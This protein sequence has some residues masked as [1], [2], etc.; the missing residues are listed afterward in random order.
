MGEG[1]YNIFGIVRVFI[2]LLLIGFLLTLKSERTY[3]HK[4]FALYLGLLIID[5]NG[6]WLTSF[7]VEKFPNFDMFRN[8]LAFLQLPVFYLYI[9]SICY[10]NFKLKAIHIL[11]IIPLLA[12]NTVLIPNYYSVSLALKSEFMENILERPEIVFIYILIHVLAFVYTILIFLTLRRFRKVYLE[13]YA[14][15]N[16]YGYKWL[17]RL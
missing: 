2:C 8:T 14:A 10:S 9:L 13:N 16:S 15:S 11:H 5:F 4:L 3:S 6:N 7:Y 1:L 12:V 17:L